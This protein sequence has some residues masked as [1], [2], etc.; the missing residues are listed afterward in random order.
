VLPGKS[1]EHS[2]TD[3]AF[4]SVDDDVN[5]ILQLESFMQ[6]SVPRLW[7]ELVQSFALEPSNGITDINLMATVVEM[8]ATIEIIC[9]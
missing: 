3:W 9:R 4:D 6:E 2:I 7:L 1:I 5:N 8:P